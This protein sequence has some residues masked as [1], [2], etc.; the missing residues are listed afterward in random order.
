MGQVMR[1]PIYL[2]H[3]ASTPIAP[4]ALAAMQPYLTEHFGNPSSGHLFGRRAR[5]GVET[6]R[7][8]VAAAIGAHPDEIVFTSGATEASN[9]AILGTAWARPEPMHVVTSAIEHPATDGPCEFAERLGARVTRVGVDRSG[10]VDLGSLVRALEM[11]TRLVTLIHGH[12]EIGVVQPVA[13][14]AARAHA[15]GALVHTD[16]AQSVGKIGVRVDEL[17]VD[18][19]SIAGHKLGAPKGVGAL[20]VRR[21]TPIAAVLRGAD[22]ERGLRPGTENVASIVALGAACAAVIGDLDVAA[23]RMRSLC[24][25]LW[26]L[27]ESAVPGIAQNGDPDRGLPNTLSVRFPRVRGADLLAGVP[28]IAA[29]TGSACH[30]GHGGAPAAILAMGV[31]PAEA[32]GTVRLSVG[33]TTTVDDVSQAADLLARAWRKVV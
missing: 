17:D 25:K 19:L 1:A 2:D 27:L 29:A 6:A 13:E 32:A 4:E 18:L 9:L 8:Q 28:E 23:P 20:Y 5:E 3:N 16:A 26:I 7:A 22:H 30:G 10:V 11:R 15:A 21:G 33:R 24:A 14:V 31:P 12:N